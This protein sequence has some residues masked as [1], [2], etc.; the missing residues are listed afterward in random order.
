[1][2]SKDPKDD[3]DNGGFRSR[4]SAFLKWSKPY[5]D[6]IALGVALVIAISGA[7]SWA[8]AHFATQEAVSYLECK[9]THQMTSHVEDGQANL[10]AAEIDARQSQIKELT[11]RNPPPMPSVSR[12]LTENQS[13]TTQ[14]DTATTHAKDQLNE[15]ITACKP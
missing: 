15:A 1:M 2:S 9:L 4:L 14:K 3:G 6:V 12:L 11:E 13:L 7:V 5:R 10:F 8:I